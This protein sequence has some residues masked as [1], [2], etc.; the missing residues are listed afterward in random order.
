MFNIFKT[1][2][3]L[4]SEINRRVLET[5]DQI[6][7]EMGADLHDDLIQ[8]LSV[9]RLYLDRLD[10]AKHDP[11]QAD[12][13]ITS[14]NADF[15]EV[16]EAVRRIS[17]RLMPVDMDKDTLE[18][19][20]HTLCQN[21]ERPGGGTIHFS[22]TGIEPA[23]NEKDAMHIL[24]IVQELINNALKHSSAWHVT[25]NLNWSGNQLTI[26]VEDDGTAFSK[27]DGFLSILYKKKNTL[28]MRSDMLKAPIVYSQGKRGLH[29]NF[30]Y[31]VT[32]DGNS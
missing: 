22:Q 24:R 11:A 25:I 30:T 5:T 8:R 1:R 13:I 16:V 23:F 15:L 28:R 6:V 12:A 7:A 20:I 4:E 27:I 2:A 17:R 19:R 31:T 10:R 3:E 9:L 21:M 14:M 32:E 29:A 18:A 26:D